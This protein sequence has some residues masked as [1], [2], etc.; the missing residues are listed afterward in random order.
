VIRR[1][2][3]VAGLNKE[4]NLVMSI[5]AINDDEAGKGWDDSEVPYF[6]QVDYVEVYNYDQANENF[7][8]R[9]RD[10]FDTYD[11]ERWGKA[12]GLT[13][14]DMDSTFVKENV[15]VEDGRL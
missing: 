9:F 8:L 7:N 14:D 11:P 3:G 6:A 2:E 5:C 15:Y 4:Q 10:D 13:W 1:K 12:D